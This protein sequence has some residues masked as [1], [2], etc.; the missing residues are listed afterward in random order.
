MTGGVLVDHH[1]NEDTLPARRTLCPLNGCVLPN[2]PKG[3]RYP[4]IHPE[5]LHWECP[6]CW[7]AWHRFPPGDPRRSLAF[8]F[9]GHP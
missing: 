7:A 9:V 2:G 5:V 4:Y 1:V 6:H 8:P 3:S